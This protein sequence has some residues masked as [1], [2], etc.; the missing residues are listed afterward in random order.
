[1]FFL[2]SVM[3]SS[4]GALDGSCGGCI[5]FRRYWCRGETYG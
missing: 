3:N 4:F 2:T 5:L 1:M